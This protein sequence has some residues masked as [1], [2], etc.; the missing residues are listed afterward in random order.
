MR[1]PTPPPWLRVWIT[2]AVATFG[3]WILALILSFALF[4]TLKHL[5]AGKGYIQE[6]HLEAG[7]AFFAG[8]LV[9]LFGG[10]VIPDRVS[11]KPALAGLVVLCCTIAPHEWINNWEFASILVPPM[12][13][14]AALSFLILVLPA[15]RRQNLRDAQL[16]FPERSLPA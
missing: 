13:A 15:K 6:G 12:F 10:I 16:L 14:G 3:A 1:L 4:G 9:V 5:F 7:W 2:G 8:L 11:L